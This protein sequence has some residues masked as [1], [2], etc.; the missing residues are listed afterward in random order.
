M[1][2]NEPE[3]FTERVKDVCV[4]GSVP[5]SWVCRGFQQVHD[6]SLALPLS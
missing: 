4:A 6:V 3:L 5:V 1:Q 2:Y